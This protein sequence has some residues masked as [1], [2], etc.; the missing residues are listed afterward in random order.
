M[1]KL[2]K[3]TLIAFISINTLGGTYLGLQE[4]SEDKEAKKSFNEFYSTDTAVMGAYDKK[5]PSNTSG[6]VLGS[7]IIFIFSV[8]AAATY[9]IMKRRKLKKSKDNA[10]YL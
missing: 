1:N 2:I 7:G 5:S 6:Y 8:G 4:Y 9:S 3:Y 10:L